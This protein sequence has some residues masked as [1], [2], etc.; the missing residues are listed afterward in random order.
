MLPITKPVRRSWKRLVLASLV[1]SAVLPSPGCS[2]GGGIIEPSQ[3]A[4]AQA[5]EIVK[6]KFQD[7]DERKAH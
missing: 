1:A 4:K 2:R 7:F 6:K 5:R 3:E